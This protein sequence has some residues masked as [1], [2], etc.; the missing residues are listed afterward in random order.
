MQLQAITYFNELVR[1]RSI[2]QAA[3][4][5]GVSPTAISRQLENLEYYFGAP[6]VERGARG[7]MLTAAGELLAARSRGVMR[8]LETA[9]QVIDDLRGLKRGRVSIH[10]NGAAINAILAPALA[11]FYAQYPAVRIEVTVSSAQA[12]LNA[13]TGGQTDMAVTMFTPPEA[14]MDIRFRLPVLHVPVMAP[15]HP[16]ANLAEIP[17]EA[18]R[19]HPIAMPDRSFGIRRAFDY[20]QRSAGLEPVEIAFTTSSLELQ[21][22]LARSGAAILILP[23]MTV[24]R[25]I[26]AGELVAI[27]FAK[28]AEIASDLQLGRAK[29]TAPSFAAARL[30]EFLEEFLPAQAKR[31]TAEL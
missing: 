30:A 21:K 28:Q 29:S 23:A 15:D 27:P 6:L 19:A 5:L 31:V 8:D 17:L 4:T 12:A 16:I 1:S 14:Q 18:I 20:R 11:R 10:V 13:V 24:M 22:E 2:R 9:R 3:E 26:R 7:I 25:E